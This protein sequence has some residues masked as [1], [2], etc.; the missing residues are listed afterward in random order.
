MESLIIKFT[1]KYTRFYSLFSIRGS[2]NKGQL[3]KGDV[4]KKDEEPLVYKL[5]KGML[6]A[7]TF[8]PTVN[9]PDLTLPHG[10]KL[11]SMNTVNWRPVTCGSQHR[12]PATLPKLFTRNL[13]V[14][15]LEV[16]K[17]CVDVFCILP[18]FLKNLLESENLICNATGGTKTAL[19][20]IPVWFNYFAASFFK[21]PGIHFSREAK[22]R[23]RCPGSVWG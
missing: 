18:R 1:N 9:G 22:E 4:A 12:T 21:A 5:W 23:K 3:L 10:N 19:G 6:T 15:F 17:T 7:H 14:C 11:L 8:T 20:I 2:W 13:V 16:D